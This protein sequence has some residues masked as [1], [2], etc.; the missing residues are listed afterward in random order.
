MCRPPTLDMY[1]R[2]ARRQARIGENPD[3]PLITGSVA[4]ERK[5]GQETEA[6]TGRQAASTRAACLS[7]A[8]LLPHS[9]RC[10]RT[11]GRQRAWRPGPPNQIC[12]AST[13]P[14]CVPLDQMLCLAIGR[15]VNQRKFHDPGPC[16]VGFWRPSALI[17]QI[18]VSRYLVASR[19]RRRRLPVDATMH[20]VP[21]DPYVSC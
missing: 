19:T 14:R 15:M 20:N 11:K 1:L 12:T 5:L 10:S 13:D 16:P 3:R 21:T 6:H 8:A 4:S 2:A 7:S 18:L 17:R 9:P